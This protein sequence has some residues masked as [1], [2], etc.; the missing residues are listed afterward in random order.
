MKKVRYPPQVKV[1]LARIFDQLVT[2]PYKKVADMFID[3]G[4]A[5]IV[6]SGTLTKL[7]ASQKRKERA[8]SYCQKIR[9]DC[10]GREAANTL[11]VVFY[12]PASVSVLM[13]E[14]KSSDNELP[15]QILVVRFHTAFV[16]VITHAN[17]LSRFPYLSMVETGD[18]TSCFLWFNTKDI[19]W[20]Q[21]FPSQ[22]RR[23]D[24][25]AVLQKATPLTI[26][27]HIM[28]SFFEAR[29]EPWED[30]LTI[31]DKT[32]Y[33]MY[34]KPVAKIEDEDSAMG[35]EV[36]GFSWVRNITTFVSRFSVVKPKCEK[37]KIFSINPVEPIIVKLVDYL[38]S[39]VAG[40]GEQAKMFFSGEKSLELETPIVDKEND[41]V[42]LELG[43]ID[44]S[45]KDHHQINKINDFDEDKDVQICD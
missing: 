24:K 30:T 12:N 3:N 36:V 40:G 37:A 6:E 28:V 31:K 22:K 1:G 43:G 38:V 5:D 19:T 45:S 26:V 13:E 18:Y 8:I 35:D 29:S 44:N 16:V 42:K 20:S 32:N 33:N 23:F 9:H 15:V 7:E 27:G 25:M 34:I 4:I 11:M 41:D 21:N 14:I 2:F 10:V 17:S 39:F